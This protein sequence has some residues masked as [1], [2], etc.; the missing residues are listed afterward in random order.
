MRMQPLQGTGKP[1]LMARGNQFRPETPPAFDSPEFQEDLAL[2]KQINRSQ[3]P[4]LAAQ[5][6]GG[7]KDPH[8]SSVAGARPC[9]PD[10]SAAG[11]DA[12]SP[13]R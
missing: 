7:F 1:W 2:L 11:P 9:I 3:T 8:R 13:V 5:D 4:P 10:T 12:A 6:T